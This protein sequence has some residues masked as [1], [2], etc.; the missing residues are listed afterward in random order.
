LAIQ[1]GVERRLTKRLR[2]GWLS[3]SQILWMCRGVVSSREVI[4]PVIVPVYGLDD[5]CLMSIFRI[6]ELALAIVLLAPRWIL[7]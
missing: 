7:I 3:A 2:D 6:G 5:D 4:R 1:T